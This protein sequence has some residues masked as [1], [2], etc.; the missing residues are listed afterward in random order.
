MHPILRN[1]LAVIGGWAAG[2]L[3]NMGLIEMGYI[4]FPV[5]GLDTS[6]MESMAAIIPT[7][8]AEY[9]IFPFLA[10]ALGT[11]VGAAVAVLIAANNHMKFAWL[12]GALFF[13]G[14]VLMNVAIPAPMWITIID[15]TLAYF[16]MTLLG[17]AIAM[18]L[19]GK[20]G[21]NGSIW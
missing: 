13:L 15:I 8:D 4:V 6:D 10:H 3:V 11:L 21:A 5:E 18:K 1:I 7:L 16:P 9:F 12:V 2:S 20:L 17:G 14:G 19:S